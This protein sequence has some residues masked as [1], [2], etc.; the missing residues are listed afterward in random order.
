MKM[1]K[2]LSVLKGSQWVRLATMALVACGVSASWSGLQPAFAGGLYDQLS[3]EQKKVID[4]GELLFYTE[5]VE[6]ATWPK[7]F[8]Y[9]RVDATPEEFTAVFTDYELQA[10]YVPGLKKS[11]VSKRIDS[12][13]AEIDYTLKASVVTEDYTVRNVLAGNP[14]AEEYRVDW[15]L[16]RA[17]ST[18]AT[19]GWAR[20]EKLGTGMLFGYY[21]FVTPGV[22]GA[23]LMKDKAARQVRDTAT[24]II[25]QVLKERQS[26]R[27]L[28][29]AQIDQL[30]KALTP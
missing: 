12:K 16:V 4:K 9:Q 22:P 18:K 5:E 11:K 23:G 21:N 24:A 6:G 10:S 2:L 30:R 17:S 29:Q 8:I 7:V 27:G 15:T 13:T 26:D 19:Q 14:R 1:S 28:L 20:M 3:P 25:A